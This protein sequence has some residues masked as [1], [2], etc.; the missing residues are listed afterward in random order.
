M[1]ACTTGMYGLYTEVYHQ[2]VSQFTEI[3]SI[4]EDLAGGGRV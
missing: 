4:Q 1:P 3:A 2:L